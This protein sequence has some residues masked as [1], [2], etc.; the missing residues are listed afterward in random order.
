MITF[1]G[2]FDFDGLH[3]VFVQQV[4]GELR[5]GAGVTVIRR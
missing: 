1:F 3:A 4:A 2:F 5:A